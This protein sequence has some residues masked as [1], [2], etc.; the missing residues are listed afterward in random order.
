MDSTKI[1][2]LIVQKKEGSAV[3]KEKNDDNSVED[4]TGTDGGVGCSTT[5]NVITT[6]VVLFGIQFNIVVSNRTKDE[7]KNDKN[8]TVPAMG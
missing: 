7:N 1:F 5:V 6:K 2:S 4:T 3:E 8:T